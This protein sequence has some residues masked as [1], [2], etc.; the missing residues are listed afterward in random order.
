[1]FARHRFHAFAL[2]AASMTPALAAPLPPT[3]GDRV[4]QS[5]TMVASAI[6]D[7]IAT[8]E[9]AAAESLRRFV[10]TEDG[11]RIY[12]R[13]SHL[14]VAMNTRRRIPL[15]DRR[16]GEQQAAEI[17]RNVLQQ[18]FSH[19]LESEEGFRGLDRTAVR[20]VFMEPDSFADCPDRRGGNVVRGTG[21]QSPAPFGGM[22][23]W[24][25]G[26]ATPHPCTGCQ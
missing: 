8:D 6:Q 1:M 7:A 21:W 13:D 24:S 19:L 11:F 9:T 22:G 12:H 16:I 3:A 10:D 5:A 4:V 26:W 17:A 18:N 2:V 23:L 14:L 25:N 20:V 15:A